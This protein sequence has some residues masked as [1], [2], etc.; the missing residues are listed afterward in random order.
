MLFAYEG[1]SYSGM[2][3][4]SFGRRICR[5]IN[6]YGEYFSRQLPKFAYI[7]RAVYTSVV[8]RIAFLANFQKVSC[9]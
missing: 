7:D 8:I 9:E 4:T 1:M 6:V 2:P 3:A 5:E